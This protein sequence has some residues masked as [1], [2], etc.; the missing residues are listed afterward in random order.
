MTARPVNSNRRVVVAFYSSDEL[1][2]ALPPLLRGSFERVLYPHRSTHRSHFGAESLA[3]N[4]GDTP[5]EMP[6]HSLL[7]MSDAIQGDFNG[8]VLQFRA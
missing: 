1:E 4:Q 7:S 2:S 8:S 6:N 5:G 3:S